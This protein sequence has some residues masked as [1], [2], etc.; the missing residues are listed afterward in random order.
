MAATTPPRYRPEQVS[1]A[2]DRAVV[3]GASMAGLFAARVLAD[4]YET[5]TVVEKDELPDGPDTR[6]GVP[7]GSQPHL[8]LQSGQ[9]TIEDFFPGFCEELL[10]ADGLL[11]D[12]TRDLHY[13]DEGGYIADGP[14]RIPMYAASRP[15]FES[16]V[17]RR[18]TRSSGVETRERCQFSSYL[19]NADETAVTGVEVVNERRDPERIAADLVVDAT[20][21]TS[22]TADW[23]DTIGYRSPPVDE[24][25]V[26]VSYGTVQISRPGD[27]RRMFFAPPS[28]PRTRGG[29]VFPVEDGR[30]LVTLVGMHGTTPPSDP[31]A[32]VEFARD[33]PVPEVGQLLE[34]REWLTDEVR[35]YPFPCSVWRHYEALDRFPANLLVTGDAVASFNPIYGQGMSIAALEALHL[36]HL[37]STDSWSDL[38][39]RFFERNAR[40]VRIA[41]WLSVGADFQFPQTTGPKPFGADVSNWYLSRLLR[42]A[43]SDGVLANRFAR[44]AMMESSPKTLV[45]PD[46]VF[47]VVRPRS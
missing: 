5:V 41:W 27:D 34:R 20:G 4:A 3:I 22:R 32:Y 40:L 46:T 26:D 11:I 47:R 14:A 39:L 6:L 13:Y 31:G 16:I 19:T 35:R 24:V 37:L 42:S 38:A 10:A 25:G 17:R 43:H 30:W 2:G 15:L 23:L 1:S 33:L 29:G 18:V 21:R 8:L 9:E 28:S 7:Q 36:H 45:H 44:V 12:W